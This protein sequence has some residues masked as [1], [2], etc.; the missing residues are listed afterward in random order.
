M[1]RLTARFASTLLILALA[2]GL[3][4]ASDYT[5]VTTLPRAQGLAAQGELVRMQL[6][7]SQFGGQDAESNV[8]YVPADVSAINDEITETLV[9]LFRAGLISRL[10]V[11]PEYKGDSYVPSRIVFRATHSEKPTVFEPNISIW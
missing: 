5:Q 10:T 11:T 9:R 3:A 6:F 1:K 4:Q 8:V 2:N 7:P